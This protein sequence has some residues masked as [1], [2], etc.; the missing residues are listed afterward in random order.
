MA[1]S[2]LTARATV[3]VVVP[4]RPVEARPATIVGTSA[5]YDGAVTVLFSGPA[6]DV[7]SYNLLCVPAGEPLPQFNNLARGSSIVPPGSDE[8][9]VRGLAAGEYTC[10]LT[11][12]APSRSIAQVKARVTVPAVP[13]ATPANVTSANATYD[14]IT[15]R[16]QGPSEGVL[17]YNLL[18]QDADAPLPTAFNNL[19]R[20]SIVLPSDATSGTIANVSA[21]EH[22]CI[23]TT[24]SDQRAIAN[25]TVKV[26]VPRRPITVA[27][28]VIES[29][30][31]TH[32]S[33]TVAFRG[34][35][36]D[37]L[38]HNLNCKNLESVAAF[39]GASGA[40]NNLE[41][42][43]V[44]VPANATSATVKGLAP[45]NYTCTLS[46][47]STDR[48]VSQSKTQVL[49][50]PAP[51]RA[52][53]IVAT[54]ANYTAITLYLSAAGAQPNGVELDRNEAV[55]EPVGDD[56]RRTAGPV[57]AAPGASPITV[58]GA[59]AGGYNCSVTTYTK[60]GTS[61]S[62]SV[63][64]SVS[65]KPVLPNAPT[66][67]GSAVVDGIIT[68]LFSGPTKEANGYTL[69]CNPTADG[70]A[71]PAPVK[72]A[73][74][75]DS[76]QVG[77]VSDGDYNCTVTSVGIAGQSLGSSV[78]VR[79]AS[80]VAPAPEPEEEE[81]P[82]VLAPAPEPEEEEEPIIAALP[83]PE[84]EEESAV[85]APNRK[86]GPVAEP[87]AEKKPVVAPAP[88]EKKEPA[89]APKPV[90]SPSPS[91]SPVPSPPTSAAAGTSAAAA[92]AG[93]ALAALALLML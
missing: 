83:A 25:E 64:V 9:T 58:P 67:I 42:G 84:P 29:A 10:V 55:C 23:L 36:A 73:S 37:V 49:V 33:I 75:A 24:I 4:K 93:T 26:T 80:L 91:P 92:F 40:F 85:V 66:I 32:D 3:D 46:S 22:V 51:P 43:S 17:S 12:V 59:S 13:V 5:N 86:I 48:L 8:A 35:P 16:F 70:Q 56:G 90:A 82:I 1:P 2:G 18:C 61:A 74:G 88:E 14:S 38:N 11:T 78:M 15:V 19:A 77:K 63:S 79:V 50:T 7:L 21:G 34:A 68:V 69:N 89:P 76:G 60:Q 71:N 45:G 31:A 20:G 47:I 54:E 41:P 81:E 72:L 27:A 44:V 87:A 53:T 6:T 65:K 57:R 28:P 30:N 52:V 62:T 39:S